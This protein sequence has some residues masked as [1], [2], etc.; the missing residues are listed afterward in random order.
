MPVLRD[1]PA[2]Y[3]IQSMILAIPDCP[4]ERSNDDAAPSLANTR[5]IPVHCQVLLV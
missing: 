1:L 4:W 3:K 5:D 2:L